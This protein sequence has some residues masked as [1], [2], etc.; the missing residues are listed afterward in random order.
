MNTKL[1]LVLSIV[2]SFLQGPLLPPVFMEGVLLVAYLSANKETKSLPGV[3]ASGLIFDLLQSQHLGLS[4]LV[5]LGA[6][7]L[8]SLL[9]EHIP[10]Y[11]ALSLGVFAILINIVRA[12]IVFPSLTLPSVA[13]STVV[14]L[15]IF[16]ALLLPAKGWL[17]IK[18]S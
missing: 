17:K 16:T 12:K 7:F 11:K 2:V 10:V 14:A 9:E 3:L 18:F 6:T 4:S 8:I 5:F 1:F 15:V 13:I